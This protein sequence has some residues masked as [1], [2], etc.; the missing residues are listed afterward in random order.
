MPSVNNLRI[1]QSF[2]DKWSRAWDGQVIGIGIFRKWFLRR[3]PEV[4]HLSDALSNRPGGR[5]CEYQWGQ[6]IFQLTYSSHCH[7]S[8]EA[9]RPFLGIQ[10]ASAIGWQYHHNLYADCL[11]NVGAPMSHK[12]RGLEPASELYRLC[13]RQLSTKFIANFCG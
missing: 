4:V 7:Y 2:R 13:D 10:A 8:P 11:W 3:G 9:S 1:N 5:C 6:W 12:F